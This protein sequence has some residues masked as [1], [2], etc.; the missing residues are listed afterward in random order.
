MAKTRFTG[1]STSMRELEKRS[2][3]LVDRVC[4]SR[5]PLLV[6]RRGRGV[7]VLMAVDEYEKLSARAGFIAAVAEGLQAAADDLHS[8]K[9]AER[10]LDGFGHDDG[11]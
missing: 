8:H 5:R 1:D 3:A 4:T 9:E 6:T 11:W 10:I 2:S 7:A